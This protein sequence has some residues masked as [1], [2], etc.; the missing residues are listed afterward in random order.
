MVSPPPARD[1][2]LL[3]SLVQRE[4]SG[5]FL[6]LFWLVVWQERFDWDFSFLGVCR[7]S[8]N[9][10]KA[11]GVFRLV[12]WWLDVLLAEEARLSWEGGLWCGVDE[13]VKDKDFA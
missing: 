4:I 1:P 11:I 5:F 12:H 2:A 10:I 8:P 3:G 6:F 13:E 9:G 7:T